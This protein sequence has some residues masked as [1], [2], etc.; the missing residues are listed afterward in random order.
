MG[1]PLYEKYHDEE[2]GVPILDDQKLFECLILEGAQAGL[3]WETILKKRE[4]YREAYD[5]FDPALIANYNEAK[6]AELLANA[7]IVRNKLK[8]R[9]SITNAQAFHRVVK[10]YGSFN[11]YIWSF[12]NHQTIINNRQNLKD[13]P[14]T[15]AESDAMS[16]QL[17]KDGFKFV[18]SAICYAFMQAVGIVNDHFITC[19]R[20]PSN[21]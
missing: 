9:A 5:Q 19:F 14:A 2:W 15:T 13:L 10:Q 11:Q 8:V 16:K 12:T 7:G 21:H 1:N 6:V 4:N 17:K 18:G 3:S 20:H